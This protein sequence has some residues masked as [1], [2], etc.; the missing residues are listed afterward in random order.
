MT[1]MLATASALVAAMGFASIAPLSVSAQYVPNA[2]PSLAG[3]VSAC[4]R[5]FSF[6]TS[7]SDTSLPGNSVQTPFVLRCPF[8][9]S[10]E[11]VDPFSLVAKLGPGAA[12]PNWRIC[13]SYDVL[14]DCTIGESTVHFTRG[15]PAAPLKAN[16]AL[17]MTATRSPRYFPDCPV[18]PGD[19]GSEECEGCSAEFT[20]FFVF[21]DGKGFA[22]SPDIQSSEEASPPSCSDDGTSLTAPRSVRLSLSLAAPPSNDPAYASTLNSSPDAQ[23]SMQLGGGVDV[24]AAEAQA[25]GSW[26]RNDQAM[27]VL[28]YDASGSGQL[29]ATVNDVQ[30]NAQGQASVTVAIPTDVAGAAATSAPLQVKLRSRTTNIESAASFP[31]AATLQACSTGG[32]NGGTSS[33]TATPP[34]PP[35]SSGGMEQ[36]STGGL[37]PTP[38]PP[39]SSSSS[40]ASPPP[41]ASSSSTPPPTEP[42]SSTAPPTTNPPASST[43]NNGGNDGGDNGGKDDDDGDLNGPGSAGAVHSPSM[44]LMATAVASLASLWIFI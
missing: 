1:R 6:R 35:P 29:L 16:M 22:D 15:E 17:T 7:G 12:D 21:E 27:D 3:S 8:A 37:E 24:P 39:S 14:G 10:V 5:I 19:P 31:Q 2:C 18:F 41:P 30:F 23:F 9:A 25:T 38:I 20:A 32:N 42:S 43:G 40:T 34:P 44:A 28:V 11:P 26:Q 36:S 4:G 13:G 33:S